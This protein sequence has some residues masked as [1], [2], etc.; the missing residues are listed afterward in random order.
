MPSLDTHDIG[1]TPNTAPADENRLR[2]AVASA[3]AGA[4]AYWRSL[5]HLACD[6]DVA[7]QANAAFPM[8]R[9][10]IARHD[11]R[12]FLTRLGAGLALAGMAGCR[13]WPKEEIRP[14]TARPAGVAPGVAEYYATLFELDGVA[15][16]ILAKSYDGRPIKVEG[17]PEHPMS[18]GAASALAQ[19]NLLDLYD[20]D[21]SRHVMSRRSAADAGGD[22]HRVKQSWDA[23]TSA[24]EG[25]LAEHRERGGEGLAVLLQ[26]SG[27][28]TQRRLVDELKEALP[29]SQ[30]FAYQPIHHDHAW[31]GSRAAFG[32]ALRLH[33]DLKRAK[34]IVCFDADL[35]GTHPAH[36]KLARDW[37]EGRTTADRGV[38]NRLISIE[39]SWSITGSVADERLPLKPSFVE[40]ALERVAS[41]LG[42]LEAAAD[43]LN[44]A[45]A[46]RLDAL[47]D[48]LIEAG[49][50]AV[51][52]VGPA[53]SPRAHH[54]AHAINRRLG[55]AG[56]CATHTAEPLVEDA[57]DGYVR[58]LRRLSELLQGNVIRT[59][60]ILGGNP[61]YDAP[62][63]APLDLFST[64][65]RP[66]L[67][68]HLSMYD[69]ET[70]RACAWHVPMAHG[71][72]TWS[73]GRS[74]DGAYTL[75]QP[76]IL[77]LFDGKSPL[78]L[79]SLIAGRPTGDT[80][81]LVRETF[82][83]R[84]PAAGA[85]GWE[86]AIHDGYQAG[87]EWATISPEVR[88]VP[89]FNK[90]VRSSRA[91][92]EEPGFELQ[93]TADA[94]IHDGRYANN[95]W[96]QEL[97]DP[98]T[99]LTWDNAA[100]VAKADADR[101]NVTT[102][103]KI[104][105]A[106][107]DGAKQ[108]IEAPV[109]V[110]PG[111][112][113][114]C[115]SI[116]L[117]YGRTSAGRIGNRVGVNAYPLRTCERSYTVVRCRAQKIG[118]RYALATTQMHHLVESVAHF[119]LKKRLGEAGRPGLLIHETSLAE[120]RRDP[121]AAHAASHEVHAAPLF[122]K[123][124]DFDEPHKWAMAID[125]NACIGCSACVV[126]CQAENN[127]PVVGKANV[128]V[129][130]EMHWL[131]LDRYFKGAA[132][133]P[134]IVHVPTACVHCEKAPCEQ[135]CPVAATLHDSEG[136]N[137]MVY[138]RCIGTRYCSNNCPYKARRFNYFDY[139]ASDPREPAKPW[140]DIPDRQQPEEVSNFKKMAHNPE[141]TV[142]MRGVMEKCTYCVQR[143]VD[144]RIAAKNEFARGARD[145]DVVREGE[146]QTACQATCPTRAIV[147]GDLN[148]PQSAVSRARRNP[149]SYE[150]LAELNLGARTT[151]LAKI[152]NR[153]T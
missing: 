112:A 13:R 10:A 65:D 66:L 45:T 51:V 12:G 37:A 30:W 152:R 3:F 25:R 98:L 131:R 8:L 26:P 48:E 145:A 120:Y 63:D 2:P 41:R 87:S 56:A 122:D 1:V 136:L 148:D 84:F 147:F 79:L 64:D 118:G 139:Q 113:I 35:L 134:D 82:R 130:R 50:G 54:L 135:V 21:R 153:E 91:A 114:G 58:S 77:P 40:A 115:I 137:A 110:M 43:P 32:Q 46:T 22:G 102:G 138:N 90:P 53:L 23:F 14:H 117:G 143:I 132:S 57:P 55:S 123:P 39:P 133:N 80:R 16:G 18:L 116:A 36:L 89:A 142:R 6:G 105:L 101:L 67:S 126:A 94:K 68:I 38:M 149:R 121:R 93:F 125:L 33:Y 29:Q 150:M 69:N 27:S 81:S 146:V 97:P 104:R 111:Q 128:A 107:E 4:P 31:E 61:V 70:S 96:L 42:L 5:E 71:L 11:R 44:E 144:A 72:E 85:K 151:Y 49:E 73:D 28:P 108:A 109:L 24:V 88:P 15:H 103:E 100:L 127:I 34:V 20:P 78:E 17:N 59:L 124:A 92:D 83:R 86:L 7:Q 47:A 106:V 99:K 129:N 141:V 95:P 19:A 140:L 74:W 62:A 119:A 52:A 75:G 60:I 76:L 9:E